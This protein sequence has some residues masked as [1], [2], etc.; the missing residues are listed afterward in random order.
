[1]RTKK[2]LFSPAIQLFMMHGVI[3]DRDE[4]YAEVYMFMCLEQYFVFI[5]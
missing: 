4:V 1:M 3:I 2:M 5:C